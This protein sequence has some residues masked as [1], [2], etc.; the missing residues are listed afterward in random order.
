MLE[1]PYPPL[2]IYSL[3]TDGKKPTIWNKFS[4]KK[5]E[6]MKQILVVDD[7][8][9]IRLLYEE[10]LLEEG[11]EVISSDGEN[12]LLQLIATKRPDLVLLDVKL[13]GRSGLSLLQDIRN[14]FQEIPV[15]MT[16]AY[17][18]FRPDPKSLGADA[19]LFKSSDLTGLKQQIEKSLANPTP[20]E[21]KGIMQEG[22]LVESSWNL[23][24]SLRCV[25]TS[26]RKGLV[27]SG[28]CDQRPDPHISRGP[29]MANNF[30]I[31][32]RR[33]SADLHIQLKG[34]FD[35]MSAYQLIS[36]L[37]KHSNT[38]SRISINTGSLKV[39][40]LFGKKIFYKNLEFLSRQPCNLFFT[41]PKAPEFADSGYVA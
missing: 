33:E 35:G 24:C 18:V 31:I 27:P 29:E 22:R 41:G 11:Y 26:D 39:V 20:L 9:S 37:K 15:I 12:N 17:P 38:C 7:D 5:E 21:E 30:K 3:R 10:E 40:H 23:R 13:R 8:P 14:A 28:L 25:F 32:I 6:D 2:P 1:S 34:D 4:G 19:C 36:V 16:S